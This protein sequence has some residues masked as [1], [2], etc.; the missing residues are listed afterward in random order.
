M[1]R[2]VTPENNMRVMRPDI[3][4]YMD[5]YNQ[6]YG[7]N[8]NVPEQTSTY[9]TAI[10]YC[11]CEHGH[12]FHQKA[13]KISQWIQ[14]DNG[15]IYCPECHK[16]KIRRK[17]HTPR[18]TWKTSF[19][20]YCDNDESKQ[21]LLNEWNCDKN[22]ALGID[23]NNIGAASNVKV[24]WRCSQGHEYDMSISDRSKE[25]KQCPICAGRRVLQGYNDLASQYPDVALDWDYEKK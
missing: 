17:P 1:G 7:C 3:A 15:V 18:K 2:S 10:V 19:Y 11:R 23:P 5:L 4:H 24:W 16:L 20:E 6:Y 14:D 9:G 13:N 8:D 12:D 25:G 22:S 21:Y